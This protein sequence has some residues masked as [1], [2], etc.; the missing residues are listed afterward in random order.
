MPEILG[1]ALVA[2]GIMASTTSILYALATGAIIAAYATVD[3]IG[4]RAAQDSGA[5]TAW[6]L[7]LYGALLPATFVAL[8]GRLAVDFG[9]PETWKALGGGLFALLA[10]GV[11]V[12]AFAL[13]RT[14]RSPRSAKP[15]SSSPRSSEGCS[16]ARR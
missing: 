12:A 4:V 3:A 9:A 11:V 1:V 7:V 14:A 5:Y 6:V 8:R 10:Y 15:A 16:L 2:G 13:G